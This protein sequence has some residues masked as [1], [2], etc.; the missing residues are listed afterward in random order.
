MN[1]VDEKISNICMSIFMIAVSF[2]F[3]AMG[4]AILRQC[5]FI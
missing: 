4:L 5:G 2:I 1:Q 3:V